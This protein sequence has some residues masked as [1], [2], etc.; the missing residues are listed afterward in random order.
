M[1]KNVWNSIHESSAM[2]FQW[3]SDLGLSYYRKLF[4]EEN[5]RRLQ[6]RFGSVD[7][8]N[9]LSIGNAAIRPAGESYRDDLAKGIELDYGHEALNDFL[10]PTFSRLVYQ[11]QIIEFLNRFC[12]FTMGRMIS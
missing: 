10:K 9:L 5:L 3:E 4:S 7:Y 8:L 2:I 11:E 1:T 6:D 12:G